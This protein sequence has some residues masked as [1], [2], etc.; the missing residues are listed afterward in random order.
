M[1][2]AQ[3]A[4]AMRQECKRVRDS[5]FLRSLECQQIALHECRGLPQDR[6]YIPH[7]SIQCDSLDVAEGLCEMPLE[8]VLYG[9]TFPIPVLI[10]SFGLTPL[11]DRSQTVSSCSNALQ[12]NGTSP[13]LPPVSPLAQR[14]RA[15]K[16]L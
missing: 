13:C 10:S 2:A 12:L 3:S 9:Y 6:K 16:F 8:R 5:T 4:V 1:L 14:T 11:I 15:T 7:R